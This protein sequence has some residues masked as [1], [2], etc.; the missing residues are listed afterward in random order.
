MMLVGL[1][2]RIFD[3]TSR[4]MPANGSTAFMSDMASCV[5][6]ILASTYVERTIR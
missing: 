2:A 4:M 6:I 3:Y 5:I 1:V